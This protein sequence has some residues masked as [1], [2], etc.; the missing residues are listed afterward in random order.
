[1]SEQA[2]SEAD[3]VT[4]E[5]WEGIYHEKGAEQVSWYQR[6]AEVSLR[7]IGRTPGSVVDI[8]AG[9][10]VLVDELLASG[11]TDITV[12]DVS[13]EALDTTRRRLGVRA[14]EVALVVADVLAWTPGRTFDVWHDRAVFHFLVDPDQQRGYVSAAARAVAPGGAVVMGTFAADGPVECSGLPTVRRSADELAALFAGPF[15]LEH[16][17]AE[18][19]RTPWDAE[20]R[21]TWVLLRRVSDAG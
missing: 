4:R 15:V 3:G 2:G 10:S 12:L 19:H 11:R 17:E 20:Q 16:A 7:L 18:I 6:T 1:V 8:G 13:A 9:A 5:H 14:K 21:F